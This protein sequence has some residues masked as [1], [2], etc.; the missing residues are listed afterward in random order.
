[1]YL[2]VVK[3]VSRATCWHR[4]GA[5]C[6]GALAILLSQLTPGQVSAQAIDATGGLLPQIDVTG[7]GWNQITNQQEM[8]EFLLALVE[9][10]VLT[11]AITYHPVTLRARKTLADFDLP[12]MFFTYSLIGMAVGFLVMHH[13]YLIGFVIFGLGGLLRFR[14]DSGIADDKARLILVTL[15]GLTIGLDLPVMALILTAAGWAII[16]FLGSQTHFELEVRFDDK[17]SSK[18]VVNDLATILEERGFKAVGMTKSK[19]KPT[20]QYILRASQGA[21]REALV[22]EMAELHALKKHS[23]SD[24]H[25][26]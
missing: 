16:Y 7:K 24:W 20:A 10:V 3:R 4:I 8:G 1:M 25:L 9:A 6:F 14:S 23:I 15:I 5:V 21:T 2:N 22:R 17:K 18:Q 12:R 13:G 11:A 26:D 19:F